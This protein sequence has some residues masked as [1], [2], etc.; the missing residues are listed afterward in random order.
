MENGKWTDDEVNEFFRQQ[1]ARWR[2]GVAPVSQESQ[3]VNEIRA[4]CHEELAEIHR[5]R[6]VQT[7]DREIQTL[8]HMMGAPAPTPMAIEEMSKEELD[9]EIYRMIDELHRLV[10]GRK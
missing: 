4:A 9:Q 8:N 5:D 1:R 2:A 10:I 6:E 7:R 3:I